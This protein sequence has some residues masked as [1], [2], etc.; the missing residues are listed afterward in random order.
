MTRSIQ[1]IEKEKKAIHFYDKITNKVI[2]I[3]THCKKDKNHPAGFIPVDADNKTVQMIVDQIATGKEYEFL[4]EKLTDQNIENLGFILALKKQ[5]QNSFLQIETID[6]QPT[7]R[8]K[9]YLDLSLIS[10][11]KAILIDDDGNRKRQLWS[12]DA[13]GKTALRFKVEC[14]KPSDN[15]CLRCP[16]TS[17]KLNDKNNQVKV[18]VTHGRTLPKNGIYNL[19]NGECEFEWVPPDQS[20][21]EAKIWVRDLTTDFLNSEFR[22]SNTLKVRCY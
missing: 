3:H 12:F 15:Q 5:H 16:Q 7:L 2:L 22:T 6:D 14:R 10:T 8:P 1:E 11:D 18:E 4:L 21:E 13:D 19:V 9:F 20:I 17:T